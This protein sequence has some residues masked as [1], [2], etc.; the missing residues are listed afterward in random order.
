MPRRSIAVSKIRRAGLRTPAWVERV[1]QRATGSKNDFSQLL[2]LVEVLPKEDINLP[3]CSWHAV[4]GDE[5]HG[6]TLTSAGFETAYRLEG[7]GNMWK[8]T[9]VIGEVSPRSSMRIRIIGALLLL[10]SIPC[11][12]AWALHQ[13]EM[14]LSAALTCEPYSLP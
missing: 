7:V 12:L 10:C 8:H 9:M 3:R 13:Y 11:P 6:K 2:Q 1:T 4:I 5:T 14:V